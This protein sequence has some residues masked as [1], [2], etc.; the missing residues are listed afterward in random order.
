MSVRSA[1]SVLSAMSV[2]DHDEYLDHDDYLNCSY[3]AARAAKNSDDS[4]H[5]KCKVCLVKI[6]KYWDGIFADVNG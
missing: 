3:K 1:L 6:I 2:L 5:T 4:Y